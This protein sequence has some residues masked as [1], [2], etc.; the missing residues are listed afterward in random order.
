MQFQ[1]QFLKCWECSKSQKGEMIICVNQDDVEKEWFKKGQ[2]IA[3]CKGCI[4]VNSSYKE[5][6]IK[7]YLDK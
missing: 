4:E 5:A 1:Y 2:F 6:T 3:F 7:D